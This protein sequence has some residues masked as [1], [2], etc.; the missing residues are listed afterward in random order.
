M[1]RDSLYDEAY[2]PPGRRPTFP[3][4]WDDFQAETL[5]LRLAAPLVAA[6]NVRT[7]KA[8]AKVR[9]AENVRA[10]EAR[11][12]ARNDLG[13]QGP[14]SRLNMPRPVTIEEAPPS[15][16]I[17]HGPRCSVGWMSDTPAWDAAKAEWEEASGGTGRSRP[18]WW[19]T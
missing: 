3:Y 7:K 19:P 13:L 16:R 17:M 10:K 11:A 9:A 6:E 2:G 18:A 15:R 4:E 12:R 1:I 8:R 14:P 5:V